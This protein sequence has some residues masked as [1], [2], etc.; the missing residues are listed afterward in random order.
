M[1]QYNNKALSCVCSKALR[2]VQWPKLFGY[3]LKLDQNKISSSCEKI[4]ELM[5]QGDESGKETCED[6]ISDCWQTSQQLTHPS[7]SHERGSNHT[8][9]PP[10]P[11]PP[12]PA[13]TPWLLIPVLSEEIAGLRAEEKLQHQ[14]NH[15]F[16]IPGGFI[17]GMPSDGCLQKIV[18]VV[19]IVGTSGEEYYSMY[20]CDV[21]TYILCIGFISY[22]SFL[23]S[24]LFHH[25][26][27]CHR[28]EA[29]FVKGNY[30]RY[31]AIFY[32]LVIVMLLFLT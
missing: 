17:A 5:R 11:P 26:E 12:P 1:I 25:E 29:S 21:E 15:G 7:A 8:L 2:S 9:A 13:S 6:D 28:T 16:E 3:S 24:P 19:N 18:F 4:H 31:Q 14:E 20:C 10:P 27:N 23:Y 30:Q 32:I 22:L